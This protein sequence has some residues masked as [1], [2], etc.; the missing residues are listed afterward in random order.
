MKLG[1]IGNK[2][3]LILIFFI[4]FT[5]FGQYSDNIQE[6]ISLGDLLK[7]GGWAMWPLGLFSFLLIFL[8]IKNALMLREKGMLRPD[9]HIKF[10]N[11]FRDGNISEVIEICKKNDSLITSVLSEGIERIS[12]NNYVAAEVSD[13]IEEAW[14]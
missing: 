1:K 6:T 12:E 10:Q 14:K 4:P 7:Q 5:T 9:L 8:I 11:S 13:A 2:L 3:I